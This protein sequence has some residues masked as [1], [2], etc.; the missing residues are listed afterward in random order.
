VYYVA[1]DNHKIV[2]F[3]FYPRWCTSDGEINDKFGM[4]LFST[5]SILPEWTLA[6]DGRLIRRLRDPE[7]I[8]YPQS[9]KQLTEEAQQRITKMLDEAK[10]ILPMLKAKFDSH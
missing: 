3:S 9:V 10:S 7:Y 2:E 8:C 6:A 4:A 5:F 1:Y